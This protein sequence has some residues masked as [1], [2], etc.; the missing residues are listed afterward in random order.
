[1]LLGVP[2]GQ[3]RA[4]ATTLIEGMCRHEHRFVD[5]FC[6]GHAEMAVGIDLGWYCGPCMAADGHR[7]PLTARLASD[8]VE[9]PS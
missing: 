6:T 7:C 9:L 1:M 2:L 4:T 5:P 3:C 8:G